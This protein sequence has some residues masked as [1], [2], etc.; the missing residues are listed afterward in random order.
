MMERNL[1]NRVEILFPITGKKNIKMIE[2]ILDNKYSPYQKDQ[3]E[4]IE[5]S[6]TNDIINIFD[7][8]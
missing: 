6:E 2:D 3:L 7:N 8:K 4:F 1:D 5:S